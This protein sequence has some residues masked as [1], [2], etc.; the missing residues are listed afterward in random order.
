MAFL[1]VFGVSFVVYQGH[2]QLKGKIDGKEPQKD[3]V[4]LE[5]NSWDIGGGFRYFTVE[6]EENARRMR[7]AQRKL[8]ERVLSESR[9]SS[10]KDGMDGSWNGE[11]V[12]R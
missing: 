2:K 9:P 8:K 3:E 12:W 5:L 7:E 11:K 10:G 6:T 1:T 4:V